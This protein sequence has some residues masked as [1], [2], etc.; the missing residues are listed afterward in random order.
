MSD[1]LVSEDIFRDI[2]SKT[3]F[4]NLYL[5]RSISHAIELNLKATKI[6][7]TWNGANK[8]RRV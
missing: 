4:F 5:P 3:R 8:Q 7:W 2:F 6:E 1:F